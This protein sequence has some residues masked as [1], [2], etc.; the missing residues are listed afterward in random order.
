MAVNKRLLQGAAAAG[1]LVPS[2]HFGVALYEGDG[3]SGHSINGGK[4]GAGAATNGSNSNLTYPEETFDINKSHTVSGWVNLSVLANEDMLFY[5]HDTNVR[6]NSNYSVKYRRNLVNTAYD[7]DSSTTLST[8]TWYHIVFT[9]STTSGMTLYIN[10]SSEGTDSYTGNASAHSSD[11]GL[12]Y[13]AD[14]GAQRTKGK[15]DQV[16]IFTKALTSSEVS[17]LYAETAATVESLDP[18]S[19]DTTDTLQ[20]LGDSSCIATYRFENDEDDLSGN[21]DITGTEIQYAAGRYGQAVSMNGGQSAGTSSLLEITNSI[22]TPSELSLS[23]WFKKNATLNAQNI[24]NF[25]RAA[26]GTGLQLYINSSNVFVFRITSSNLEHFQYIGSV[27]VGNE[28]NHVVITWQNQASGQAKLYLNNNLETT[29]TSNQTGAISFP[30]NNQF[31]GSE[32]GGA[33]GFSGELDQLRIFNKVLSAA[34][35][36]LGIL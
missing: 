9:F 32:S 5:N 29:Q 7:I 15:I 18:L 10:G 23:I 6:L 28:W 34:V 30:G 33:S 12:M 20:V 11:Y 27:G 2:E 22:T 16:R 26:G 13:R 1:G 8:N 35:V 19:E 14:N 24:F 17:T 36:L 3:S 21:Y 25:D 31:V 4:F